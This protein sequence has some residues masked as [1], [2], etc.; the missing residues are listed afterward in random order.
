[1]NRKLIAMLGT[2][3][4]FG[5]ITLTAPPN[6]QPSAA[7]VVSPQFNTRVAEEGERG[8]EPHPQIRLALRSLEAARQRLAVGAH[9]F[10]GHRA[11]A[12]ALTDRAIRQLYRALRYDRR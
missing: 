5:A 4:L 6:A 12:L 7:Q 10:G 3:V 1:M 8:V 9:D 2:A 11:K